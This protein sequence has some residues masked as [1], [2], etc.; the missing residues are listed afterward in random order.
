MYRLLSAHPW[1]KK[2][3]DFFWFCPV[4]SSSGN[5]DRTLHSFFSYVFTLSLRRLGLFVGSDVYHRCSRSQPEQK[6]KRGA[7]GFSGYSL[8]NLT[9]FV[10]AWFPTIRILFMTTIQRF[11]IIMDAGWPNRSQYIVALTM[12][13]YM[14]LLMMKPIDVAE[15]SDCYAYLFAMVLAE[16]FLERI[17]SHRIPMSSCRVAD[18]WTPERCACDWSLLLLLLQ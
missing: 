7:I 6:Y 3:S 14:S 5:F 11:H 1:K 18:L 12:E 2:T 16:V 4:E 10:I 15:L 9:I 13:T 17:W 8:L